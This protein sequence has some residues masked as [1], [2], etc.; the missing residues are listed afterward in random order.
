M[1]S[2]ETIRDK[3]AV[4]GIGA[5]PYWR[6][7]ESLPRTELQMTC[8]AIL[9]ALD[10]AGLSVADLDGFAL[11][12]SACDP[13]EVA[14]VLG[15]PE[16]RF[17]A[18]LTSGGGGSAGALGLAAA[19]IVAGQ[20]EVCVTVM[21][22]QQA[23]RRLGGGAVDSTRAAAP[24]G[25]PYGAALASPSSAFVATSGL[26]APGH[27]FS[28]IARRHME[29]YGTQREHFAEVCISTRE[30]ARRRPTALRRDPLTLDDYL[31][32][33]MISDPLCLYDYTM[34][35]DGAVWGQPMSTSR[36]STTISR[37]W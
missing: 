10:D 5:T 6:R 20:A 25:G 12:A 26:L 11:Y 16:I 1:T 18:T 8:Q 27:S 13:A 36:C 7:G 37:R 17:A 4:V 34:E 21:A 33:R 22:L 2:T 32:A 15:V 24:V 3:T 29:L 19:A 9:A 30:N 14:A 23:T 28:L 35:S 31:S